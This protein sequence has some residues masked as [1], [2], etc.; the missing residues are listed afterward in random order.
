MTFCV[1]VASVTSWFGVND[2]AVDCQRRTPSYSIIASSAVTVG[3]GALC[4]VRYCGDSRRG[5]RVR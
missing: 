2:S 1:R 3:V 5:A 4:A